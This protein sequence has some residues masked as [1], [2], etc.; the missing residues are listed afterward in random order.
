MIVALPNGTILH[1]V[2][3]NE[4]MHEEAAEQSVIELEW[5]TSALWAFIMSPQEMRS[6]GIQHQETLKLTFSRKFGEN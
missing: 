2:N 6:R 3:A 4:F 5:V 1:K